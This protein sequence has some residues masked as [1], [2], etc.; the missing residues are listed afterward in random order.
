[1]ERQSSTIACRDQLPFDEPCEEVLKRGGTRRTTPVTERLVKSSGEPR[2]Y[3]RERLVFSIP[4][5]VP[6]RGSRSL[7]LSQ[8]E[9]S[10][11]RQRPLAVAELLHAD[12]E[13]GEKRDVQVRERR[14]FLV[15]DVPAAL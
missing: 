7:Q 12:V 13:P 2:V 1:M 9:V 15:P 11:V 8:R 6:N 14:P 10:Q 3:G 5:P 4:K